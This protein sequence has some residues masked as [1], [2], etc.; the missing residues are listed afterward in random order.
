MKY[1]DKIET[2]IKNEL[3]NINKLENKSYLETINPFEFEKL[4]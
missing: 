4:I 3:K 2:K 1:K